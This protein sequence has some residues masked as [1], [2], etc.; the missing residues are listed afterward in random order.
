MRL[1]IYGKTNHNYCLI[2][3]AIFHLKDGGT[4]TLDR[5]ETEFSVEDGRLSM[6]WKGVYIWVLNGE[7]FALAGEIEPDTKALVKLLTGARIELELEDDIPD[8][9]YRVTDVEWFV[10]GNELNCEAS[11][12]D[13]LPSG[14]TL[15]LTIPREFLSDLHK[16]RFKECFERVITELKYNLRRDIG[17]GTVAG[18]YEIETLDMLKTAFNEAKITSGPI[19]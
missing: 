3:T 10:Y 18:N 12:N 15:E 6:L 8:E 9:D 11:G 7:N 17:I 13:K 2:N 16:D 14:N 4:L 1:E 19:L 5:K